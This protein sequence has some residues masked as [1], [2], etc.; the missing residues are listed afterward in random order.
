MLGDR[1][2]V[3]LDTDPFS[4][5]VNMINFEEVKVL[6]RSRQADTTNGKKVIL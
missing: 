6:V 4:A 1:H 2:H 5:N 3:R